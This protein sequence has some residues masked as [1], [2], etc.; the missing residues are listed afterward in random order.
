MRRDQKGSGRGQLY[1]RTARQRHKESTI[2]GIAFTQER[3]KCEGGGITTRGKTKG[4]SVV[5]AGNRRS[6]LLVGLDDTDG[7][8]NNNSNDDDWEG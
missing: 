8:T 7:D 3:R 6:V 5:Q 1:N 2:E 4:R